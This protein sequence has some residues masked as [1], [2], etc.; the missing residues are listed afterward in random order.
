M[1]SWLKRFPFAKRTTCNAWNI[2]GVFLQRHLS[3]KMK[4]WDRLMFSFRLV[5]RGN[6]TIRTYCLAGEVR[7]FWC[8]CF[9]PLH[10]SFKF[11]CNLQQYCDSTYNSKLNSYKQIEFINITEINYITT[12]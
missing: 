4:V 1:T 8:V 2:S 6:C 10:V 7:F 11:L 5:F 9:F 12:K 3:M